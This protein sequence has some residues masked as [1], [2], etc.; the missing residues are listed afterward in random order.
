MP[1]QFKSSKCQDMH[2]LSQSFT[3]YLKTTHDDMTPSIL[4][5]YFLTHEIYVSIDVSHVSIALLS[6]N[7]ALRTSSSTIPTITQENNI[8]GP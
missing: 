2:L 4:P 6:S 5:C 7:H 8:D 1:S 3:R